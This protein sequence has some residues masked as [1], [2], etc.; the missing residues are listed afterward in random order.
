[1]KRLSLL[2]LLLRHY[3][4]Y[5]WVDQV[6]IILPSWKQPNQTT[7]THSFPWSHGPRFFSIDSSVVLL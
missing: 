1:M 4:Y 3:Y 2:P 5:Y 7:S 6:F